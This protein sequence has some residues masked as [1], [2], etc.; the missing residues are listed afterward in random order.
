MRPMQKRPQ[1]HV[2]DVVPFAPLRAPLDVV[3]PPTRLVT[4]SAIRPSGQEDIATRAWTEIRDAA[5]RVDERYEGVPAF[6]RRQSA[7]TSKTDR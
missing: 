7:D 2:A 1:P 6:G 3:P 5:R 4:P